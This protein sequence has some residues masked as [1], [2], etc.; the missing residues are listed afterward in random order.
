[1]RRRHKEIS[2]STCK[3]LSYYV[4]GS[5]H[6]IVFVHGFP[7]DASVW[8]Q[9]MDGLSEECTCIAIDLPGAGRSQLSDVELT[10]D[11]MAEN[12]KEVLDQ[13]HVEDAIIIGHSMG[14]YVALAFA[15]LFPE[16]LKALAMVHSTAAADTEEKK[17]IR[18]KAI[19]I[20]EKGGKDA[21]VKQMVPNLLSDIYKSSHEKEFDQFINNCLKLESCS[22]VAFY[23]AMINRKDRSNILLGKDFPLLWII[24]KDDTITSIDTVKQHC[25]AANVN[26]VY[27]YSDCA[28]VSM[29]EQPV[30]LK[31][32]ISHF[33]RYCLG[34]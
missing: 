20:I 3:S 15:D 22:L 30:K 24:G 32:D 29:L 4:Q 5:G 11:N 34:I 31:Q 33:L 12:I 28:H 21:F 6:A 26:F 1:M 23:N 8:Y 9:L 14:G 16:R 18:R 27:I 13:E 25:V 17:T 7:E 19:S 2:T 10:I